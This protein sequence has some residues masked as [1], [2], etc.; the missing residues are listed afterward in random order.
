MMVCPQCWK[1]DMI[2]F[3][4]L[5]QQT[6]WKD[7]WGLMLMGLV[8]IHSST[9]ATAMSEGAWCTFHPKNI[10]F[11]SFHSFPLFERK[12][13]LPLELRRVTR[14]HGRTK[15]YD[16]HIHWFLPSSSKAISSST[17]FCC[18]SGTTHIL[19]FFW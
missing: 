16:T 14:A 15:L 7:D 12:A 18:P 17:D 5:H 1:A 11:S 13:V 3:S 4:L 10:C 6:R 19:T 9:A 8:L 2:Q